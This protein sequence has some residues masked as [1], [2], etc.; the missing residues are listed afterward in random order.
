MAKSA[1]NPFYG[2]PLDEALERTAGVK[3]AESPPRS[4]NPLAPKKTKRKE[5]AEMPKGRR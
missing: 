2:L 4:K 3:P 5:S 1:E